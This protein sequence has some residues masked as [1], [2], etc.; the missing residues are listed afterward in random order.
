MTN[1][2]LRQHAARL[3]EANRRNKLKVQRKRNKFAAT[4][5]S[6]EGVKHPGKFPTRYKYG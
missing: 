1:N 6:L 2:D 5:G 3:A 4:K